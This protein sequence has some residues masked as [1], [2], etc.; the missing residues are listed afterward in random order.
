MSVR[1]YGLGLCLAIWA[2]AAA[3]A[4]AVTPPEVD[5]CK[6]SGLIALKEKSP[7]VTE[8]NLDL[9]SL[10]VIKTTA[11]IED[12]PIKTVVLGEVYIEKGKTGKPQ[13]LVCIVGEKGKVLLTLFTD[14]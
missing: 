13:N 2:P 10:R 4:Q 9:D 1:R 12:V 11:K 14:H 8:I 7:T 3:H 5:A 6:A